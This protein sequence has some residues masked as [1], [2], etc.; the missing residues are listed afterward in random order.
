MVI[1][2]FSRAGLERLN[3]HV[4][5]RCTLPGFRYYKQP[6]TNIAQRC[7]DAEKKNEVRTGTRKNNSLRAL[8]L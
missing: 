2:R 6:N 8:A 5:Q 4:F 7:Q 1:N 3:D